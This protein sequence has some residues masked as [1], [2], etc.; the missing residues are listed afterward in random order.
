M[1]MFGVVAHDDQGGLRTI[2]ECGWASW[3]GRRLTSIAEELRHTSFAG[4]EC[5]WESSARGNVPARV[6]SYAVV[7]PTSWERGHRPADEL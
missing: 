4:D 7:L 2:D 6:C 5:A 1:R 3:A